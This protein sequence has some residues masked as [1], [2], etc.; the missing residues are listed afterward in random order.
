MGLPAFVD[1]HWDRIYAAAQDL[2]LSMNFHVGFSSSMDGAAKSMTACSPPSIPGSRR[3]AP[4]S[5]C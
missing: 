2:D 5:G 4:P 3:G 1:P